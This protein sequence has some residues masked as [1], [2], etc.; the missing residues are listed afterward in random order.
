MINYYDIEVNIVN[1]LV[2][3]YQD[4]DIY[5]YS[6]ITAVIYPGDITSLTINHSLIHILS[7]LF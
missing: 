7:S 3:F 6:M 2:S 5:S 4:S 1:I